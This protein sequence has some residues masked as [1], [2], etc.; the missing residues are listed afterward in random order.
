MKK[1]SLGELPTGEA[2]GILMLNNEPGMKRRLQD[3]GLSEGSEVKPLF[4]NRSLRAYLIK[5]AVIAIRREDADKI[6]VMRR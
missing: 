1:C 2:A 5:E 4:S 3:I 6:T